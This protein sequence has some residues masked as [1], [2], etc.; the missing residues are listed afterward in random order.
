MP[1]E[2][3]INYNTILVFCFFSSSHLDLEQRLVTISVKHWGHVVLQCD[4]IA[5]NG[6]TN[7][8]S[9]S[10]VFF[11]PLRR[12]HWIYTYVH[13]RGYGGSLSFVGRY[14]KLSSKYFSMFAR[15]WYWINS[16]FFFRFLCVFSLFLLLKEAAT[17]KRNKKNG[18]NQ[19]KDDL[20]NKLCITRIGT[21][22]QSC[23]VQKKILRR[24][25]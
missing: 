25:F 16:S 9:D 6:C 8:L 13:S 1:T 18:K 12:F 5:A 15:F 7:F 22:L 2:N 19:A 4:T 11:F 24:C 17:I 14:S 23:L 21:S 3:F 20:W 10:L